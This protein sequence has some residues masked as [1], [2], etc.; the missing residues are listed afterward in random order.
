MAGID[1]LPYRDP[2]TA[3]GG[4]A[5]AKRPQIPVGTATP[6]TMGQ[7][8]AAQAATAGPAA[9]IGAMPAPPQAPAA[10]APATTAAAPGGIG[11]AP[12]NAAG[13]AYGAGNAAAKVVKGALPTAI[14]A[15]VVSDFNNYKINDPEVDSSAAGTFN[16]VRAGDFAGAAKS[17][18]K[19]AL[20]TLMDLGSTV[21][22]AADYV[23]PGKAPVSTAYN[24]MLK[25]KFGDL[26]VDNTAKPAEPPAAA[27]VAAQTAP[28]G[29]GAMPT[30]QVQ[31]ATAPAPTAPTAP[32][33]LPAGGIT[34]DPK[35]KTYSGT[36]VKEGASISGG[37]PGGRGTGRGTVS[38]L[39]TSEGFRQD[40]MEAQRLVAERLDREAQAPGA[41]GIAGT[42]MSQDLR[43]KTDAMTPKDI[44]RAATQYGSRAAGAAV[45]AQQVQQQGEAASR[46]AEVSARA[47]DIGAVT[48]QNAARTQRDIATMQGKTA[49]D[50]ANISS[51]GRIAAVEAKGAQP[52]KFTTV[53]LPD[54]ID[55]ATGQV[56]RG[57]QAI[58]NSQTN[59]VTYPGQGTGAK[60]A[61]PPAGAIQKLRSDPKLAADFDAKYGKGAAAAALGQ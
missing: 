41:T 30:Q 29:I 2:R 57:G 1:E 46:N 19:G 51:E 14:G 33:A 18:S 16:A 61:A 23:V 32:T 60:P 45:Q 8:Q 11:A 43:A 39:D 50:V 27:P 20:E 6:A 40:Q 59:E 53:L 52:N 5:T 37:L 17:A 54:Q 35:T 3:F 7:F 44:L 4:A 38:S 58:V 31:A 15:G 56:I 22:N 55:P 21:A 42:T 36:D 47:Q 34:Y 25:S 48:Q 13:R 28:S 9:G 10:P 49:R 24:D 12:A 26:L